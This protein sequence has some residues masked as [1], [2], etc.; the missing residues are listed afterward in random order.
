VQPRFAG[1]RAGAGDRPTGRS[2][3][4][5]ARERQP[6][7]PSLLTVIV[8]GLVPRETLLLGV[9]QVSILRE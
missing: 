1:P 9:F 8:A 7:R 4:A 5:C 2:D 6:G 3:A